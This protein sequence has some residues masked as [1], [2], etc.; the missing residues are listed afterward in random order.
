MDED[1]AVKARPAV[2]VLWLDYGQRGTF[3]FH[4]LAH[5]V[6]PFDAVLYL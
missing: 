2:H 6:Y 3:W 1:E 5:K 4:A